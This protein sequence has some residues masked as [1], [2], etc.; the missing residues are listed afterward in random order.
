MEIA[1]GK[2]LTPKLEYGRD[3][4]VVEDFGMFKTSERIRKLMSAFR[5]VSENASIFS[6]SDKEKWVS[7][8]LETRKNLQDM[9]N[10]LH[11]RICQ[12]DTP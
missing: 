5:I 1:F 11:S 9:E 4:Y 3:N 12:D 2:L 7:L 10:L 6:E 8:E